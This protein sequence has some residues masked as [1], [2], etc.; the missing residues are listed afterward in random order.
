MGRIYTRT[1]DGGETSTINGKR[2]SK[3]S[4]EIEF[5]GSVDELNSFLGLSKIHIQDNSIK[6]DIEQIQRTLFRIPVFDINNK[7][8]NF[9]ESKIDDMELTLPKIKEFIVPGNSEKSSFLHISRSVCRRAERKLVS[10][11]DLNNKRH[12]NTFKYMNRL[13]DYLF[14]LARYVDETQ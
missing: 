6:K 10:I 4:N 7:D 5:Y 11:I 1:G 9:L 2:V 12:R 14:T 3:N 13:S 8:I